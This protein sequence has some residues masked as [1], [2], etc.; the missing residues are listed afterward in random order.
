MLLNPKA[1]QKVTKVPIRHNQKRAVKYKN[2]NSDFL[3]MPKE[4]L[5]AFHHTL[6]QSAG[7]HVE[8]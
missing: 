8:G 2:K 3:H 7:A 5:N 1:D 4:G 6:V